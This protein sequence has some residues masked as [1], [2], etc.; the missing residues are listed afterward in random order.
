M[1]TITSLNDLIQKILNDEST[2]LP[3]IFKSFGCEI[4]SVIS[5]LN[6][7]TSLSR[8]SYYHG[9]LEGILY[10]LYTFGYISIP[11]KDCFML[12]VDCLHSNRLSY[13]ISN[14]PEHT[15]GD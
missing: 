12:E 1:T 7:S 3:F 4:E 2:D 5:D 14:I 15:E 9:R 6:D 8:L 13:I 11:E 10:S